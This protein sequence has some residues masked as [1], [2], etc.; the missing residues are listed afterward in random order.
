[1]GIFGSGWLL[2]WQI[3]ALVLSLPLI[4]LPVA[5]QASESW[6]P[7]GNPL[8]LGTFGIVM[9]VGTWFAIGSLMSAWM[10]A[11]KA[12]WPWW[13]CLLASL[14]AAAVLSVGSYYIMYGMAAIGGKAWVIGGS[15][16]VATMMMLV[17]GLPRWV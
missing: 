17:I 4:V 15:A 13:G 5:L 11:A 3:A 16:G 1:V 9:S 12:G 14:A 8:S 7:L 2:A 6:K 10:G